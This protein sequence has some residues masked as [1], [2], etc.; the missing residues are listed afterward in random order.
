MKLHA[1]DDTIAAI[2]TPIG[3][4][5]IGI[6]RLSGKE[7]VAIADKIFRS[8]SGKRLLEMKS[9]TVHYGWIVG[10]T[11]ASPL[12]IIDEVLV[13][14]M[15]SPKSYTAEDMVEISCNGGS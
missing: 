9:A 11:H 13:T 12:Q 10:A 4:G 5:G 8:R 14:V 3:E 1:L 15:R 6:V 7:A 2:S